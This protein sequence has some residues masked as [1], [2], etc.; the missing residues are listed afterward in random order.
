MADKQIPVILKFLL[1]KGSIEGIKTGTM[2][3]EQG[4]NKLEM[5]LIRNQNALVDISASMK[6]VEAQSKRMFVGSVAFISGIVAFS[7]NYVKNLEE[8][9]DLTRKWEAS[10]KKVQDAQERIGKVTAQ[11]VLPLYEK[12]A[13]IVERI[14]G[15]VE[16]NPEIIKA[17]INTG[18]FVAGFSALT[19]AVS[20]GIRFVA[21]ATYIATS[22]MQLLAS[23]NMQAAA[24]KQLLASTNLSGGEIAQNLRQ[25]FG[26]APAAA[27]AGMGVAATVATTV[28]V[29]AGGAVLGTLIYDLGA[30]AFGGTRANVI[31]TGGAYKIGQG[32]GNIAQ[33][34]GMS[35]EEAERKSLVFAALIGKVTGAIDKNSPLW[36]NAANSIKK[37]SEIV[38]GVTLSG[39]DYEKQIVDAYTQM[40]EDDITATQQYNADRKNIVEK[41][42]NDLVNAAIKNASAIKQ[43]N[44][45]YEASI[46]GITANYLK[47]SKASEIAYANQRAQA[48]R[49]SGI[50][51]QRIEEDLQDKLIKL[52]KDHERNMESLVAK[53]D[54]LGLK[55]EIQSYND[56]KDEEIANTN[57]EIIRRRE[58]LRQRLEDMD[59]QHKAER[60]MR[61]EEYVASLEEAKIQ[62]DEQLKLQ[63]EKY[64]EEQQQIRDN[65]REQL[66]ELQKNYSEE[67]KRRHDNFIKMVKD[68]DAALLGEAE[69]KKKYY[70]LMLTDAEIFLQQYRRTLAGGTPGAGSSNKPNNGLRDTGGYMT[71]GF[72]ENK[73]GIPEMVMNGTTTRMAEAQMGYLTQEKLQSMI[74]GNNKK[75]V[76]N[77]GNKR[78][79]S[80]LSKEDRRAIQ[81]DIIETFKGLV[82]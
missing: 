38:A 47:Q 50:E 59:A 14:A 71:K 61:Y 74:S 62:R 60:A 52:R 20:K 48:I 31:A 33:N 12:A 3:V 72:Y 40:R 11:E 75:I 66:A 54:A 81:R 73:N 15:F 55:K 43:I 26:L 46:K 7:N 35:S 42:N 41:A 1:D 67:Q 34:F 13:T 6:K 22:A 17:A 70:A 45:S 49:S 63:R 79:D 8:T 51:I 37:A 24:N 32:F 64:K 65:K 78:F 29:I 27:G 21:D 18:L 25:S 58:D 53:R 23:K 44:A 9:N 5:T 36:I 2:S 28:A 56:K 4:F 80:R 39:S 82:K 30:K 76:I 57:K 69:R 68:L 77:E 19:I 10:S 16:N